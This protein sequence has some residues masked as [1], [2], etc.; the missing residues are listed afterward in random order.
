M[1]RKRK[2]PVY[3]RISDFQDSTD[4]CLIV[5]ALPVVGNVDVL[6]AL[7]IVGNHVV[8]GFVPE[9]A[10]GAGS[11]VLNDGLVE[12]IIAEALALAVDA[13]PMLFDG[14]VMGVVRGVSGVG[15]GGGATAD[16]VDGID[17]GLSKGTC[18]GIHYVHIQCE[19]GQDGAHRGALL[20]GEGD[21]NGG[22]INLATI[23]SHGRDRPD[24]I[25]GDHF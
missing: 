4:L 8:G 3:S 24:A 25:D 23:L 6:V 22:N 5:D 15:L 1:L 2:S 20:V 10:V 19:T 14:G 21:G 12:E 7:G 17:G 16:F 9:G 18:L 11:V 13:V